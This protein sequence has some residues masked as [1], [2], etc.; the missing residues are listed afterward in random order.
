MRLPSD[1][2]DKIAFLPVTMDLP[3][4]DIL[5]AHIIACIEE[6]AGTT[7]SAAELSQPTPTPIG[8][9]DNG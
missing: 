3:E 9:A 7:D 8:Q 5:V 1:W 6:A 2:R 4:Q